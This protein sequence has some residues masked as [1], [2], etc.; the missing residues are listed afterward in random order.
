MFDHAQS[1]KGLLIHM[2]RRLCD[3]IFGLPTLSLATVI[4]LVARR[5]CCIFSE[6]ELDHAGSTVLCGLTREF[7][8]IFSP[9]YVAEDSRSGEGLQVRLDRGCPRLH[10]ASSSSAPRARRCGKEK[11]LDQLG[12]RR[13]AA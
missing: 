13:L 6:N 3:H 4:Q 1:R 9:S 11:I 8:P 2:R 10:L 5:S 12:L 7:H